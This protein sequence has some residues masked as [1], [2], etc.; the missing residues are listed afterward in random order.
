MRTGHRHFVLL[1]ENDHENG[2]DDDAGTGEQDPS[3]TVV[4]VEDWAD[5]VAREAD[6]H[7]MYVGRNA[8]RWQPTT[9]M[10]RMTT[11]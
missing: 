5:R 1:R 2:V 11:R 6:L 4:D 9:K 8:F 10:M 7:T 3:V